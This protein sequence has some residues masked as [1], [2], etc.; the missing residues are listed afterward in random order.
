MADV[1]TDSDSAI[2]AGN[3]ATEGTNPDSVDHQSDQNERM[4][5]HELM[6]LLS[7]S[8]TKIWALIKTEQLPSLKVNGA[9]CF[10]RSD[11]LNW[12]ERYRVVRG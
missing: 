4:T 12:M 5:I 9:H 8:Q 3:S 1:K 6:G 7:M 11:V 10:R 2:T